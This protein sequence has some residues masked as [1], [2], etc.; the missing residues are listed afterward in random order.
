MV[1]L[2]MQILGPPYSSLER[3]TVIIQ[4]AIS[5]RSPFGM[6]AILINNNRKETMDML[7]LALHGLHKKY[8]WEVR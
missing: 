2:L 1:N 7:R 4:K 5:E 6:A 3:L 8:S